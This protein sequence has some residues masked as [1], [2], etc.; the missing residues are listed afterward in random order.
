MKKFIKKL[1][2]FGLVTLLVLAVVDVWVS[3]G[4]RKSTSNTMY[5]LNKIFDGKLG[6]DLVINGS[7]KALVHFSPAILD[8]VLNVNSYNLALDGTEFLVQNTQYNLLLKHNKPPKY[9]IQTVSSGTLVKNIEIRNQVQFAP[10]INV[11]EVRNL[12]K[13]YEGFECYDYYMPFVRYT[14]E[15]EQI[16]DGCASAFGLHLK[17]TAKYKGYAPRVAQWDSSFAEFKEMN[18][19]GIRWDF[20]SLSISLFRQFL[21]A[22]KQKGIQVFLVYPPTYYEFHS[23]LTNRQGILA[24]YKNTADEYDVP[25]LDYSD[26]YLSRDKSLFYNSQHLNKTGAELFTHLVAED[27]KKLVSVE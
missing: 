15:Y 7:S 4:L 23:Y 12:A 20:D 9:V 5:T 6:T 17:N 21:E 16:V 24:F 11:S 10:Y 1:S 25:F 8:S 3:Y 26:C 14:G 19:K 22:N 13:K 27:I 2:L 18:S